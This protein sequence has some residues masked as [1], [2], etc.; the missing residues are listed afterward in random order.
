MKIVRH[1]WS[2]LQTALYQIIDPNIKFQ[3]HCVAY[4]MRSKTGY[5]NDDM[6]RYWITIGKKNHMGLSPNIHQRRTERTV[7][8]LDGRYIRYF[9]L[10]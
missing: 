1:R 7:L 10:N 3:I 2:K 5:A 6:P 8:S 4:P 9:L